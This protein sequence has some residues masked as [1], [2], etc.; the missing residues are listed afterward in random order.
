MYRN[1][2]IESFIRFFFN[3]RIFRN[4]VFW[5]FGLVVGL[6]VI[7]GEELRV[8]VVVIERVVVMI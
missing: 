6:S 1:Y 5:C 4:F 7:V 8:G 3:I 2:N